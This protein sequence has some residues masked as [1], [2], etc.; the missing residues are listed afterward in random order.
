M[1]LLNAARKF[2]KDDAPVTDSKSDWKA[3]RKFSHP[4]RYTKNYAKYVA[5]GGLVKPEEDAAR[6]AN[7]L[8]SHNGDMAR[9]Y[10]LCLISDLVAKQ[11]V[12]GDFAELGVWQGN[13]AELLAAF[14]RRQQRTLYLLDTFEGFPE[15]DLDHDEKHL[16]GI[17][18]DTSFEAVKRRVGEE[19]TVFVKGHFPETATQLPDDGQYAIVHID[20]DLYVPMVAALEYFYPRMSPGGFILMHDYG[21]L[22][23]DGAEKAVDEFF[24]DK[25]EGVMPLPD[26]CS[27]VVMRKNK[28]ALYR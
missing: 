11:K 20:C 14:A 7:G 6:F 10:S 9:F 12:P 1:S 19:R 4:E 23:W 24:S 27:T 16:S 13:T 21:S 2:L 28:K 15:E 3:Q 8:D 26:L 5:L 17:F 22:C 25:A 18:K